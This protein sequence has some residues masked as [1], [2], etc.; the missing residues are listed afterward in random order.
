MSSEMGRSFKRPSLWSL[1]S[2]I[3][4]YW[5]D[6]I[7]GTTNRLFSK[8]QTTLDEEP[9]ATNWKNYYE[10]LHVNYNAKLTN[11]T[12]AYKQSLRSY[13]ASL[14]DSTTHNLPYVKSINEAH[15]AYQVLSNHNRRRVYDQLF[16]A[17]YQ[18]GVSKD[19]LTKEIIQI[20][21]LVDKYVAERKTSK[22][23]KAP[24]LPRTFTRLVLISISLCILFLLSGTSFALAQ[25]AHPVAKV[26]KE[27]ALVVLK[28]SS[29]AIGLIE[30][31]REVSANSERSIMQSSIN[32]MR[33][34]EKS[35]AISP[36]TVPT[37]DMASFPSA[38]YPLFP[39][40]LDR[41]YSQ[42]SYTID[43]YGNI[44]VHTLTAT[45]DNLL[46]NIKEIIT[47]LEAN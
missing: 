37:N 16:K 29:S 36:V 5:L 24:R 45:T 32:A 28:L 34:V 39:Q 8:R 31:A 43:N 35:E 15:E 18:A 46:K 30:N 9:Y 22:S 26:F 17:N 38:D 7:R 14:A 44:T 19:P 6:N 47:Q 42:F 11:I 1:I 2:G 10:I 25:P 23:V 3:S 13:N 27:P 12:A 40:Y 21:G 20:S 41:R 4:R 33:V